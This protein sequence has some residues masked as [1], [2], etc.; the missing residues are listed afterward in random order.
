MRKIVFLTTLIIVFSCNKRQIL[1]K[2]TNTDSIVSMNEISMNYDTLINRVKYKGN[3]DAYDELFYHL[4]DSDDIAR[5]DTLMSYSEIMAERYNYKKAYFDYFK[6][7]C[8]KYNIN[9][10]YD[11]Y[12][13][14][15]ISLL[16]KSS[17]QKAENWLRKMVNKKIISE[18]QY[19]SIKK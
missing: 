4:M 7:Y 6:A 17:K 19:N 12:S 5:T 9:V 2:A 3:I 14:I 18:E 15:N 16:D 11:N 10:D 8:E 1:E 13:S